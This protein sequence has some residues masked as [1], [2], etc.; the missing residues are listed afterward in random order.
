MGVISSTTVGAPSS[1]V[2]HT[3]GMAGQKIELGPSGRTVAENVKRIREFKRLTYTDLS[4]RVGELGRTIPPLAIRRI[5]ESARRV[6]VDDLMA[7]AVALDVNPNALLFPDDNSR[8]DVSVKVT[9]A[10]DEVT[11]EAIW[12]W[13]QGFRVLSNQRG[14]LTSLSKGAEE[15]LSRGREIS[16]I[17]SS[18]LLETEMF[19]PDEGE[20]EHAVRALVLGAYYHARNLGEDEIASLWRID[21]DGNALEVEALPQTRG[22]IGA[23]VERV[24]KTVVGIAAK[25][26]ES[27]VARDDVMAAMKDAPSGDR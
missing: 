8:N 11:G 5:E 27:S 3:V 7:L 4:R 18:A 12:E 9:A 16:E 2:C 26:V 21:S 23:W 22:N 15:P 6:D 1:F 10:P 25:S 17:A 24:K 19:V 20:E 14:F 13:A